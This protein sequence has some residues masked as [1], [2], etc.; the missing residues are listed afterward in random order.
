[1]PSS[2]LIV[3]DDEELRPMLVSVLEDEGYEVREAANGERALEQAREFFFDLII[4]DVRMGGMDGLETA[5]AIHRVQ[6]DVP[7]I[8]VTGYAQEN[9]PLRAIRQGAFDYL[10]KPFQLR[11]LLLCVERALRNQELLDGL[12]REVASLQYSLAGNDPSRSR[13]FQKLYVGVRSGGL[14]LADSFRVW[15]VLERTESEAEGY[16]S[17]EAA[18]DE[19]RFSVDMSFEA[20]AVPDDFQFF[21]QQI[22][23][24]RVSQQEALFFDSSR[25][26]SSANRLRS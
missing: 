6:P 10:F 18:L 12:A 19:A 1:M 15:Q 8:V 14:D 11:E 3:E 4:T 7:V 25:A 21:Y 26:R 22:K 5:E 17:V 23:A 9:V 20:S 16:E 2:I 24:G 13:V